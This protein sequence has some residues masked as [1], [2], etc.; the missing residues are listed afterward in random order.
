MVHTAHGMSPAGNVRPVQWKATSTVEPTMNSGLY[1]L[2]A[3]VLTSCATPPS[4]SPAADY[5]LRRNNSH[6]EF[7]VAKGLFHIQAYGRRLPFA[8]SMESARETWA[9]NAKRL[10]Q[11][12]TYQELNVKEHYVT[13]G[14]AT[15]QPH[16][17][18]YAMC[19]S[20]EMKEADAMALI[21]KSRL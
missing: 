1:L 16:K 19:A 11:S 21:R 13:H 15:I 12:H 2:A 18:G 9:E 3:L 10:C 5:Y 20:V 4:E 6:L 8:S 7:Q 14:A 17:D